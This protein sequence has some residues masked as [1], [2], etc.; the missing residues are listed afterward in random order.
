M[1]MAILSIVF[2]LCCPIIGGILGIIGLTKAN[3][4]EADGD[5]T[6][7]TAKVLSIIGIVIAVLNFFAG[8]MLQLN[9]FGGDF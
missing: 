7:G 6:A 4:A 8:I 5:T 9:D 3:A 1:T 2:A